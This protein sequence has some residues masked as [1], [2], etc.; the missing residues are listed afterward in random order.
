MYD[1]C[2]FDFNRGSEPEPAIFARAGAKFGAEAT[3][4]TAGSEPLDFMDV[5][6]YVHEL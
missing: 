3:K 6:T 5:F 2:T 1:V 4:N